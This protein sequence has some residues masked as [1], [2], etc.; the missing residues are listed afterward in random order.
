MPDSSKSTVATGSRTKPA[1]ATPAIILK[2]KREA[3]KASPPKP[4]VVIFRRVPPV[5]TAAASEPSTS[6]QTP[7]PSAASVPA[8]SKKPSQ[9]PLRIR[10][11]MD[12]EPSVAR[13]VTP[14]PV[15]PSEPE[16][17]MPTIVVN[18][19]QAVKEQQ[20]PPK[21]PSPP[22]A[23]EVDELL[24]DSPPKQAPLESATI[25]IQPTEENT[26]SD[27][28]F[29]TPN[30]T[31]TVTDYSAIDLPT[32]GLRR[33]TRSRRTANTTD[34]FSEGSSRSTATSRRKPSAFR[35]EDVFSGMSITA[36]KDL[37]T[38]NTVHNQKY[39]AARLETEVIRREGIRP[40]SPAMKVRTVSQRQQ[41]EREKQ[42]AER[43]KRRSRRSGELLDEDVGGSSDVGYSSLG[44]EHASD[45]EQVKHQRGAGDEEDYVTPERPLRHLKRMRLFGDPEDEEPEPPKRRVKWDRGLFTTVYLD[46]VQLGS[47]QTTKENMSL[48]GILAPT[49]KVFIH[50][51]YCI[52]SYLTLSLSGFT[53]GHSGKPAPCRHTLYRI[54]ARK[55][56]SQED[57]L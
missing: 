53:T 12:P 33:T 39:L 11:V 55:H 28:V 24:P 19:P 49:A 1:A 40:E 22:Q 35:S 46:E 7:I 42:R 15:A 43:A 54:G 52:A 31:V 5:V 10:R 25:L 57:C 27:T 2:R 8:K 37:T 50:H 14:P 3:E 29:V 45:E 51:F 30:P 47:R 44:E 6:T 9:G 56:H 36:L 38:S 32:S 13:Q 20:V 18:P 17:E 48:R 4:R 21:E 26:A 41:D 23:M 34:V 16:V